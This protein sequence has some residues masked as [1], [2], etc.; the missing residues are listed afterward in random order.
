MRREIRSWKLHLR[1]DKELSDLARM[2]NAVIRGWINY[3]GAFYKSA[4]NPVF[5]HLNRILSRWATKKYRRFRHH[6]R[7][8]GH[9]LGK[10]ARERN[11]LFYHWKWGV[12]PTVE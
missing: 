5:Q 12:K 1:T 4:L 3:Y 6:K 7:K 9:W 2:F 10:V 8:A 11:N